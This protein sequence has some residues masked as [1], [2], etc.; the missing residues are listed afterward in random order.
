M[1]NKKLL[2]TLLKYAVCIIPGGIISAM[3]LNF[4]GYSSAGNAV[5]R[6]R[7]LCDAFT[8]PGVTLIMVAALVFISN[9][10]G[11]DGIGYSVKYAIK[12]LLP[13]AGISDPGKYIDYVERRRASRINGYSFIWICGLGFLAVALFFMYKFYQLY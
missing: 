9:F 13:F 11:F 2:K 3:V 7:I 8:I 12:R 4:H 5:E 1:N 10:G 6:Y